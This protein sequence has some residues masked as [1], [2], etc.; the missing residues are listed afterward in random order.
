MR[1]SVF[2]FSSRLSLNRLKPCHSLA[3]PKSGS[4]YTARLRRALR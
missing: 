4:T 1:A 3:S 2:T